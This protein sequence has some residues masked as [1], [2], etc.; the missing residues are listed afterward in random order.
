MSQ[1]RDIIEEYRALGDRFQR[2]PRWAAAMMAAMAGE[3]VRLRKMQPEKP[4]N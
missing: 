4:N 3:I 1:P 2:L